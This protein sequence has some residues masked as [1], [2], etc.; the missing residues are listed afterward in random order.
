MTTEM[1]SLDDLE[2]QEESESQSFADN[3]ADLEPEPVPD[4]VTPKARNV[5]KE[6]TERKSPKPHPNAKPY[7]KGQFVEPLTQLY[8]FGSLALMPID[9]QCAMTLAKAAPECAKAWDE[10]ADQNLAVRRMLQSLTQTGAWGT[11]I[12]AHLPVLVAVLSHHYPNALPS[13]LTQ[14]AAQETAE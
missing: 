11:V 10:L 4:L 1:F 6:K 3:F 12:A 14:E 5:K 7:R 9:P 13:M 2:P 8:G